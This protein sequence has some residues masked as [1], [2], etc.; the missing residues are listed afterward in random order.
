[1]AFRNLYPIFTGCRFRDCQHLAEP[2]C[3]VQMAVENG[4][5]GAGTDRKLSDAHQ[6]N[7]E[8]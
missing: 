5:I 3:T 7:K 4:K 6:T 2:G 1:M 8:K